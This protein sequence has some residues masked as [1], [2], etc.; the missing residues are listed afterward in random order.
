MHMNGF[1]IGNK[2]LKVQ[3]KRGEGHEFALFAGG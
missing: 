1:M 2:R 3:L